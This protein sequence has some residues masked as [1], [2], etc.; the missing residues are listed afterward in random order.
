MKRKV[1]H[2]ALER[3]GGGVLLRTRE[4]FVVKVSSPLKMR[5]SSGTLLEVYGVHTNVPFGFM[6]PIET[7]V[8]EFSSSKYQNF[9]NSTRVF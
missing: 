6:Y 5:I 1:D 7:K 8:P 9:T 3:T 4:P 2:H